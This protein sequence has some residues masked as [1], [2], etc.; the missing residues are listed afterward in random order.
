LLADLRDTAAAPKLAAF[1]REFSSLNK[2]N[3][4]VPLENVE[5]RYVLFADACR[6]RREIAFRNPLLDFDKLLFIKRHLAIYNHMCDQYYGITARPGGALCVLDNP[7]GKK[8]TG[9][10]HAV[11]P[12]GRSGK[13][14]L[15]PFSGPREVQSYRTR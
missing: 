4:A 8:G 1:E 7:F 13:L 14:D 11:H 10:I 2:A 9:P 5:A 6:L 12:P 3:R 15:S